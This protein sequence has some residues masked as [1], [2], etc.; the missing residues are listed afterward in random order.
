[1]ERS[2]IGRGRGDPHVDGAVPVASLRRKFEGDPAR[3][4]HVL[5]ETGVGY[6][7]AP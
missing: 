5:T 3:S 2:S 6:R 4:R 7:L 1:M